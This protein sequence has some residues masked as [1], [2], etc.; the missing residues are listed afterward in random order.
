LPQSAITVTLGDPSATI[1]SFSQE[2]YGRW[3]FLKS[4]RERPV[5]PPEALFLN[6]EELFAEL[7]RF[8]RLSLAKDQAAPGFDP[9]PD[10]AVSRRADD[11]VGA[12]RRLLDN[13][14]GRVVLCADSPGRRETLD[15]MLREFGI[16]A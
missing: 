7:K 5:L 11:P 2:T 13:Y 16:V 15:E 9:V 1:R 3:Q 8:P 6:E 4:D 10:V 14:A 12:L